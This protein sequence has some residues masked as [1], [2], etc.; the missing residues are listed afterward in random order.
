M[1]SVRTDF[2]CELVEFNGEDNHVHLLV[3]LPPKA[4]AT[5]LVSSLKDVHLPPPAPGVPRPGTALPA[6]QQAPVRALLRRNRRR[7]PAL[8]SQ[9]V[10]RAT[11]PQ[12]RPV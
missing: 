8:C 3:N 6:G 1:R 10:H 7:R 2:E 9:A 5:K 12:N 4:T 11:E